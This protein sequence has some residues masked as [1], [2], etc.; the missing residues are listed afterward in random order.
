MGI[1]RLPH[2]FSDRWLTSPSSRLNGAAETLTISLRLKN[3]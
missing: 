1:G 2:L 3:E